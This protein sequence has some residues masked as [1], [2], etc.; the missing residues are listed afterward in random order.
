MKQI[1]YRTLQ[2]KS[3]KNFLIY[4]IMNFWYTCL[5]QIPSYSYNKHFLREGDLNDVENNCK[6]LN[7]L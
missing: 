4:I 6:Q 2:F 3:R 5:G 1:L 7:I